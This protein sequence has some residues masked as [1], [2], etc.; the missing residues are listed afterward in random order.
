MQIG[1]NFRKIQHFFKT[2][3]LI[4]GEKTLDRNTQ[5]CLGSFQTKFHANWSYAAMYYTAI[6][7]LF[8]LFNES[9]MSEL[10]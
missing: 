6:P 5:G 10:G 4:S 8:L 7:K 1:K 2:L 9:R 3:V